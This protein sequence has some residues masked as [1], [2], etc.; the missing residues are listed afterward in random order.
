MVTFLEIREKLRI[1]YGKF[2]Y[3]F[4][5]VIKFLLAFI[6]LIVIN[7]S[8]GFMSVLNNIAI[9]LIIA[10]LCS[11]L[12]FGAMVFFIGT[13]LLAHLYALSL[14]LA[15]IT[16][17]IFLLMFFSYYIFR[18]GDSVVLIIVPLLF[19]MKIPY[20]APIVLGL[21]GTVTS[22]IPV[23]FGVV[24]Y[25]LLSFVMASSST[26]ANSDTDMLQNF[27][28]IMNDLIGQKEMFAVIITFSAALLVVYLIRKLS[29]NHS[30]QIAIGAGGVTTAILMLASSYILELSLSVV[31]I[32]AGTIISVLLALILQLF[33]FTVDYTRMEYTQFQDD[34]YFYYVKAVPK[35][36]VTA[37]DVKV[38][39]I[40]ISKRPSD[41][42]IFS[43]RDVTIDE[44]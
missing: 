9:V 17:V 28:S 10:L 39:K 1:F 37:Q 41:E 16:G 11:I 33:I 30:W 5:P 29:I 19:F 34:N 15:V 21:V 20:L 3:Y 26:L 42:D 4:M 27:I 35:I 22:I 18:P 13:F 40:N 2:G 8:L 31:W 36:A 38:K 43:D 32:L 25:Y 44:E 14:E 7:N 6:A 12:P 23:G 24:I